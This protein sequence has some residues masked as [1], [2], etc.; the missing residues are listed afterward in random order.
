M[1]IKMF[2]QI[3][4]PRECFWGMK[5]LWRA[6][7]SCIQTWIVISF[8]QKSAWQM[9]YC[10]WTRKICDFNGIWSQF[11][12][13][14]AIT[15]MSGLVY[16]LLE[17]FALCTH[18]HWWVDF[19]SHIPFHIFIIALTFIIASPP[20]PPPSYIYNCSHSITKAAFSFTVPKLN[21]K[22]NCGSF[23]HS[24]FNALSLDPTGRPI[25]P[26][27]PSPL[28][29]SWPFKLPGN[30]PTQVDKTVFW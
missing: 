23:A 2:S 13:F 27:S 14:Y 8:F 3:P 11:L 29:L 30:L 12:P 4:I 21:T 19:L 7:G 20:P 18:M 1:A 17:L 6:I 26:N 16:W 9:H 5:L 24:S 22:H 28:P 15:T 25:F 10:I